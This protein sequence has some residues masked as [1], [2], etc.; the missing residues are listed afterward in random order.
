MP[1][2]RDIVM[3]LLS[4][5]TPGDDSRLGVIREKLP[6]EHNF[7]NKRGSIVSGYVAVADVAIIEMGDRAYVVAMFGYIGLED[8]PP[9]YDELD[10]TIEEAAPLIWEYLNQQ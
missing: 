8:N 4:E 2:E 5:Y 10:A 6:E 1:S 3:E 9:T 7:I